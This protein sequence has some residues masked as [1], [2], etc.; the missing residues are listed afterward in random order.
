MTLPVF[1]TLP[2][3]SW[4]V[5]RRMVWSSIRAQSVSGIR[6]GIS[7]RSAPLWQWDLSVDILRSRTVSGQVLSE[8]E[9]LAGFYNSVAGP[10]MPFAYTD[11]HDNTAVLQKFG[12]GNGSSKT[13]QLCRSMGGFSE[14]VYLASVSS[15][16]KN[17]T[18]QSPASWS[19]SPSG[20]VT[21]VTAPAAGAVMTWSG[22]F[23]WLC[24][25]DEDSLSI[26]QI[27]SGRFSAESIK[28]S[29]ELL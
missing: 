14:P 4:P 21:L 5:T 11:A 24:R 7:L 23:Q 18:I 13:F 8:M 19:V 15:V 22:T 29:S 28:F 20:L 12:T 17:G 26:T 6:S 3:V 1:P 27:M 10:T 25:F 2:G 9:T 16:Y